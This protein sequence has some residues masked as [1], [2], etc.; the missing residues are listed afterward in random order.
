MAEFTFDEASHVY[1]LAGVALP[2]VTG[3]IKPISPDFSQVP[4]HTLE[5][6]R[7][8]GQDVHLGCE[9]D[10]LGELDEENTEPRIMQCVRAWQ[11]FKRDT[12]AV[13]HATEQKLYHPT[14]MFAG[15]LDGMLELTYGPKRERGLWLID[16]KTGVE[17]H[18][19]YGVQ[20]A[21]YECLSRAQPAAFPNSYPMRRGTV[22]LFDDGRYRLHPCTNPNDEAAFR[23]CLAIFQWKANAK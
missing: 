21:G 8:F 15:T 20:T 5:A 3:I 14:L 18:A 12:E 17:A 11:K 4:P 13:V 10:D 6:K 7:R 16:R 23:A 9:L 2:S 1:R 22:H 19:S